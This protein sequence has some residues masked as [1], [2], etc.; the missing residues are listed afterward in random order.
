MFTGPTD[1]CTQ[2]SLSSVA[3]ISQ[4]HAHTKTGSKIESLTGIYPYFYRVLWLLSLLCRPSFYYLNS[5]LSSLCFFSTDFPCLIRRFLTRPV[6]CSLH[7]LRLL[8]LYFRHILYLSSPL[9]YFNVFQ[10]SSALPPSY[11]LTI[12]TTVVL[13]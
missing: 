3:V 13:F 9:S 7:R 1:L 5:D 12:F 10:P 4:T 6:P 2:T 11:A 8:L